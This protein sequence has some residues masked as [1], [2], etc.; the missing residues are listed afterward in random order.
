M[1]DKSLQLIEAEGAG[2]VFDLS[3]CN[4]L[5]NKLEPQNMSEPAMKATI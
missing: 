3:I 4:K 5:Q 2:L 1:I